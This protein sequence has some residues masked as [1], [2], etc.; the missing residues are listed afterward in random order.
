[1][2]DKYCCPVLELVVKREARHGLRWGNMITFRTGKSRPKLILEF[3]KD[4]D[5]KAQFANTTYS[6]VAFCPFCGTQQE[7]EA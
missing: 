2:T 6:P 7:T 5:K 1:M 4:K 3:P